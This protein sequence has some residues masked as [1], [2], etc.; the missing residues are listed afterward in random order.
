[1][2]KKQLIME[3]ALEL[4]AEQGFEATSVQ[5]IT[6][7]CGISKGAFYLSFKSK[8]ELILG[9]IDHFMIEILMDVDQIVRNVDKADLLYKYYFTMLQ[10]FYKHSDFA[11]VLMKEPA[12]YLNEDVI[13]KTRSYD[14]RFD[15]ILLLMVERLYGEEILHTKYDLIYCIKG[16]VRIYSE[17]FLFGNMELDVDLLTKSLVEK[18]NLLA[19][20]STIPFISGELMEMF[21]LPVVQNEM[22]KEQLL[23]L[24][25]QKIAEVEEPIARESLMLLKENLINPT[26]GAAI[27]KGLTENIRKDSRCKWVAYLI[28]N[29]DEK[30]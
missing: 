29:Y 7:R 25:E 26:L 28:E 27:V 15:E 16:F 21:R 18:T 19:K 12:H 22:T 20:H 8:D 1:M 24:M 6:E 10:S 3:K 5:Q 4:F 11:K 9:L 23:E 2:M 14:N 13:M 17:L 30:R